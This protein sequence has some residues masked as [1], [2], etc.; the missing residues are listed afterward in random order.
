MSTS[1]ID[2]LPRTDDGGAPRD[3]GLR[4]T[5][6]VL[7]VVVSL[8]LVAWGALTLVSLLARDTTHRSAT[9]EGVRTIDV[10][11]GFESVT[12]TGSASSTAV[13]MTRS[14]SWSFRTPTASS[15][16]V[17]DRLVMTSHCRWDVG[18]GCSG[19]VQLQ[20][21]RGTT[22]RLH[23][24]DGRLT[25][26]GLTGAVNVSSGDGALDVSD[27]RGP[28]HL[29]TGDGSIEGRDLRSRSV[30]VHTGDGRVQLDFASAPDGI[31]ADTGDGSLE[32]SVPRDGDPWRVDATT[33]DGSRTIDVATDPAAARHIE[34]HTGDGPVRVGYGS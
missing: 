28:L 7:L 33:G 16:M 12:V 15:R 26:S 30:D 22:L 6:R 17:G 32:V 34:L 25:V 27:L 8:L 31:R 13:Q 18:L 23:T 4:T 3:N 5:A 14:Y 29:R 9:Y 21:P 10:D 20:V 2:Q 24:G 1:P 19:N 11:L